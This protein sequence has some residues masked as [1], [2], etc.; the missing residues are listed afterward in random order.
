M[1]RRTLPG[2]GIFV[3]GGLAIRA[4]AGARSTVDSIS[5]VPI[6]TKTFLTAFDANYSLVET[7]SAS[8]RPRIT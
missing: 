3:A 4:R 8:H 1:A 7:G 6:T 2:I 5:I